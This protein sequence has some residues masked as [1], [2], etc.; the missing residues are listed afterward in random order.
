MSG[1]P[2]PCPPTLRALLVPPR[3]EETPHHL[4]PLSPVDTGLGRNMSHGWPTSS[5]LSRGLVRCSLGWGLQVG[6]VVSSADRG[7]QSPMP[8]LALEG[9]KAGS[10]LPSEGERR[11]LHTEAQEVDREQEPMSLSS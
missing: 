10:Q 4:L 5:A 7:R 1:T 3:L 8:G 9:W 2:A 11:S 6:T